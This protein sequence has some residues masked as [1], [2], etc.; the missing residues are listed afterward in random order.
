M[1]NFRKKIFF[2]HDFSFK[3]INIRTADQTLL[4]NKYNTRSKTRST[5]EMKNIFQTRNNF[6]RIQKRL[7]QTLKRIL[8]FYF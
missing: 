1:I 8:G 2:L 7:S 6:L 3:P 5:K 4:Q